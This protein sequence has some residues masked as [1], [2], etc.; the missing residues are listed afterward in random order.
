M[1]EGFG[2]VS[3]LLVLAENLRKQG[4]ECIFLVSDL[5]RA[6]AKAQ[7]SG[8]DVLAA[9]DVGLSPLRRGE[10]TASLADILMRRGYSNYAKLKNSL[11]AWKSILNLIN[12][13]LVV[14][15]YAPTARLAA[16]LQ[17]KTIVIGTGFTIPASLE[18]K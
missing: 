5:P 1:G 15:D 12:P 3:R 4:Y 16:G 18:G 8:F 7:Q 9:P 2:H 10:Q 11:S 6:G 17:F 14:L 13:D